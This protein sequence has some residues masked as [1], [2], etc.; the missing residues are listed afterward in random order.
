MQILR[1]GLAGVV[2]A[3]VLGAG[4]AGAATM[5]PVLG[6]KLA[7]MGEHGVVNLQSKAAKGQLCWTFDVMTN[8][9]HRRV[10]PR[11]RRHD[12]REARLDVQGEEL[13]D[14]RDEGARA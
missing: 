5:H 1:F 2:A 4:V 11:R 7:G 8:G 6:A 13:R 12:R 14:G 10:D 3:G 9:H